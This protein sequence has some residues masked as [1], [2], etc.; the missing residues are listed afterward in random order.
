MGKG[1]RILL[2]HNLKP[3]KDKLSRGSARPRVVINLKEYNNTMNI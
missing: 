1:P 3:G 2:A